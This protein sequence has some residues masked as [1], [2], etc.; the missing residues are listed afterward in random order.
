MNVAAERKKLD[1]L[2]AD[3]DACVKEHVAAEREVTVRKDDLATAKKLLKEAEDKFASLGRNVKKTNEAV[4]A[5]ERK[6]ERAEAAAEKAK[7]S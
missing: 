1:K 7:R 5:Q 2:T 6:V 4:K 3:R